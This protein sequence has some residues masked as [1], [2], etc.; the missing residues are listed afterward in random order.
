MEKSATPPLPTAG[1]LRRI[2][3]MLYESLL[4]LALWF[5]AGFLF[6]GL[7]HDAASPVMKTLFQG[8]LIAVTAAY[9]CWFWVRGQ[10]LAMK[11]WRIRVVS[12][13]GGALTY[14][15]AL[16]RFVLATILTLPFGLSELWALFDRD[17]QFLHDRLAGTRLAAC[18]T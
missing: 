18:R 14:R 13:E 16:L 12:A 6:V 4:L 17:R 15:Q 7:T 2:S 5:V 10:T 11:T 1:F 9:F 3:A 8:Y